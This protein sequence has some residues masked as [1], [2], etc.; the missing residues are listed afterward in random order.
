M[1]HLSEASLVMG[2]C[3]AWLCFILPK[4]LQ[5]AQCR[6]WAAPRQALSE[7]PAL[8]L[9]LAEPR[10]LGHQLCPSGRWALLGTVLSG[11]GV[12]SFE[13]MLVPYPSRELGLPVLSSGGWS[14]KDP[15]SRLQTPLSRPAAAPL[16]LSTY[17]K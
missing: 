10:E 14:L 11:W 15:S 3:S 8:G 13:E 9:Y 7:P 16:S 12:W 1:V 17:F 6:R 4:F 2:I 5:Y